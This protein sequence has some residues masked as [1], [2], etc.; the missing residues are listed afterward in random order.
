MELTWAEQIEARGE[1]RGEMR[2]EIL[3]MRRLLTRL[4]ERRFGSLSPSLQ[5]RVSQLEDRAELERL[6][7]R[8][9]EAQTL[10]DLGLREEV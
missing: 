3:G 9:L 2:G 4:L 10:E 7:D 8:V 5:D 1:K 6:S